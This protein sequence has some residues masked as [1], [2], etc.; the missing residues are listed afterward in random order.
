MPAHSEPATFTIALYPIHDAQHGHVADQLLYRSGASSDE[1]LEATAKALASTV[2]ELGDAGLLG[3][4]SL[5]VTLPWRGWI[6]R[7]YCRPLPLG[8]PSPSPS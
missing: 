7:N 4:R 3:S 1:P 6:G 2:Y 5:F 8:W